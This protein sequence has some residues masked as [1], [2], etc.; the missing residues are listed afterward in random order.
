LVRIFRVVCKYAGRSDAEIAA[1]DLEEGFGQLSESAM[2][3]KE[4]QQAA[5]L[6]PIIRTVYCL[7]VTAYLLLTSRS[8]GIASAISRAIPNGNCGTEGGGGN[9]PAV[10]GVLALHL[11][12]ES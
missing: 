5:S 3:E 10:S 9:A 1:S 2:K 7:M 12:P 4:A 8:A 11:E 6:L